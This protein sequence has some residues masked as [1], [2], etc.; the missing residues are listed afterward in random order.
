M[1]REKSRFASA[2]A[3]FPPTS[4]P[5]VGTEVCPRNAPKLKSSNWSTDW[6]RSSTV[7]VPGFVGVNVHGPSPASMEP[8]TVGVQPE[9]SPSELPG[10]PKPNSY[11]TPTSTAAALA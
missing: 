10:P 5:D 6:K 4:D 7:K 9:Q 2:A 1:P 8:G 3:M 11:H